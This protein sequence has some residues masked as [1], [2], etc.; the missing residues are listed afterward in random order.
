MMSPRL[1]MM[2]TALSRVSVA[3]VVSCVGATACE[4]ETRDRPSDAGVT[5]SATEA[6]APVSP[7]VPEPECVPAGSQDV[8]VPAAYAGRTSPFPADEAAMNAGRTRFRQRCALCHGTS[9]DGDGRE[10][11]FDPPAADLTDKLRAEDYLFWRI[12]AGGRFPPFCSAMPAFDEFF[13]ETAR[14]E[15][16][17][18][19]RSL[20]QRADAGRDAST[21]D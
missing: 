10:G 6:R 1:S 4:N 13:S 3:L 14:W 15:L 18:Y 17:A 12:S 16:V 7:D 21:N 19:V 20:A 8:T 9:G 5:D 2:H 11:P